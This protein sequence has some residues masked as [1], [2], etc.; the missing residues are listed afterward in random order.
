MLFLIPGVDETLHIDG[1]AELTMDSAIL[2]LGIEWKAA[3]I[4]LAH[5]DARGVFTLRKGAEFELVYGTMI[6][7]INSSEL[8]SYSHMLKD[9]IE[10]CDSAQRLKYQL[11]KGTG[12]DFIEPVVLVGYCITL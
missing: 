9:Q 4:C 8:P 12:S 6:T 7:R 10:I 5:H 3:Q 2:P 1:R 11:P